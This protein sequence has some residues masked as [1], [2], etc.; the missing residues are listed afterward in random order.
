MY[1]ISYSFCHQ[2]YLAFTASLDLPL[3]TISTVCSYTLPCQSIGEEEA[4]VGD[5]WELISLSQPTSGAEIPLRSLASAAAVLSAQ[6]T[7]LTCCT[8]R[9]I[10]SRQLPPQRA[11][12]GR[13]S[14]L[15]SRFRITTCGLLRGSDLLQDLGPGASRP[16]PTF[17]TQLVS[18]YFTASPFYYSQRA[19]LLIHWKGWQM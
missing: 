8:P 4:L 1:I 14:L 18:G 5:R 17:N 16:G 19:L 15:L 12:P 2:E 7:A 6:L 13:L 10:R 9:R 11:M 3:R